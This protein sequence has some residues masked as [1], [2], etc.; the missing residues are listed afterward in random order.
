MSDIWL[1]TGATSGFGRRITDRAL[2]SGARVIAVG[3]R[4][5]RLAQLAASDPAGQVMPLAL[6]ITDPNAELAIAEAIEAAGGLDVLVNNA[7]YGAF[8]AVEQIAAAE[9]KAVFDTNVLA[10]LAVLRAS[11]PALRASRG[12]VVQVSSLNGHVA[13][14]A[15]GVYSAS[16][17]ALE[18]LSESLAIEL[19]PAGVKVTIIQPGLFGTDFAHS[20]LYVPPAEPYRPTVGKFLQEM[21]QRPHD[22]FGDPEAVAD[23]VMTVV[24]ADEPPLRLAVGADA[25]DGIRTALNAR[26]AELK[27]SV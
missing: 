13:W 3:R 6:D 9:A 15:S 8:G 19:A 7:G 27:A 25:I 16:K 5:D 2:A 21:S 14:P 26:L 10:P 23:A 20:S 18:L 17:A 4:A 12:R 11:L 22:S 24:A 1:V